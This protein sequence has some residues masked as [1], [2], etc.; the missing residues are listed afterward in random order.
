MLQ[1]ISEYGVGSLGRE[2]SVQLAHKALKR[3]E[4]EPVAAFLWATAEYNLDESV[5][6]LQVLLGD[7]MVWGGT[8]RRVWDAEGRPAR[9]MVLAVLGGDIRAHGGRFEKQPSQAAF[10]DE[11]HPAP[12]SVAFWAMEAMQPRLPRWLSLLSGLS[13]PLVGGLLG[14]R[15]QIGRPTL[16]GGRTTGHGGASFLVL[17]G[18]RLGLGWGSGWR[19]SGLW[20][21][22]S[23]SSGEWVR[24]LN[25]KPAAE[26][27]AEVFGP[28]PRQWAY[29]PL[30]EFVRLYP[31]GLR[32]PDGGWDIRA[33][34]HV[35]ADGSLRMTLPVPRGRR[36][37][38]MVGDI[39]DAAQAAEEALARAVRALEG[40]TPA[41]ALLLVDWAWY[42]LFT[43]HETMVA[44]RM[45]RLL[46]SEIPLVG[47][48]TY[49]NLVMP[50]AESEA[51]LLH[52]HLVVALL[53]AD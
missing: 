15:F 32:R 44:Q 39:Q 25:D 31:L 48:Y 23:E 12:S 34:L 3:L 1:A 17:D 22:I 14:G 19:S 53:A 26:T 11:L 33:P 20:T 37:Y 30:R 16:V 6:A 18:V 13:M 42:Y 49:G 50:A 10:T 4:V 41:L 52:N 21:E 45:R 51:R 27:L 36:A 28:P 8:V 2:L 24:R 38:W 9:G 7:V 40:H 46:G 5:N 43:A 29:A 35:E 47:V